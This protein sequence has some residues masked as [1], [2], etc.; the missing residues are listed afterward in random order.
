S[1]S[2]G[3]CTRD[4]GGPGRDFSRS[5]LPPLNHPAPWPAILARRIERPLNHS[6]QNRPA[7]QSPRDR[8]RH[9]MQAIWLRALHQK[10]L[11]LTFRSGTTT[12]TR[13][14]E[15]PGAWMAPDALDKLRADL[16]AVARRTLPTGELT[17]GVLSG[18]R[19]PLENSIVTVIYDRATG[20]PLAFNA[21]AVMQ[22]PVH[23]RPE[24][25][26]HL[27]L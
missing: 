19:E 11:D 27:G 18:R 23:G 13:I 14:V 10:R 20:R 16:H 15:R 4:G 22:V 3:A 21:L 25:V 2:P 12:V 6:L 17:Y 9:P 26:L 7:E 1:R 24:E 5:G 8:V